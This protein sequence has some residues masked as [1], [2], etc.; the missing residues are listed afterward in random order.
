MS[1][2]DVKYKELIRNILENGEWDDDGEVRPVYS[3]GKPAHSKS[4]FGVQVKFEPGEVP[5][6]TSKKTPVQSSINEV[7]HAFF[8]LKTNKM[9]DFRDLG[10]GYWEEWKDENDSLGRSYGYQLANQKE[11]IDGRYLD[12]VDA[13]LYRLQHD[14][15]SRR[16]MF[17]YWN[18][19][20]VH[21]KSLQECC[22]AGQF[23][24]RKG[25][26]D[27]LL[28]QRSADLL[29][30]IPSNWAGYFALQCTL[31]QLLDFEIGTFTHQIGNLHLYSNQIDLAK[32]ILDEPEFEQP[33]IYINDD[34]D[35]FCDY[36]VND[37][38][39]V[40]YKHGKSFRTDVAI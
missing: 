37:I 3:N 22:W 12:Q 36:E 13:I 6:V 9:Q 5:V 14:R 26:L 38:K 28:N 10:I 40:N 34:V 21:Q 33:D 17:S 39:Y 25:R 1:I 15:N 24:V 11:L 8:R 23:N 7:V 20:E 16:I 29:H 35:N 2:A 30:G 18:P 19:N 27:F 4:I 32:Q 31:A